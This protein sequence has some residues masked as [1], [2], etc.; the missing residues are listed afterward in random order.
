MS[1]ARSSWGTAPLIKHS[2]KM[3]DGSAGD[4]GLYPLGTGFEGFDWVQLCAES[5][6]RL[7]G[8]RVIVQDTGRRGVEGERVRSRIVGNGS[9]T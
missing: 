3:R 8:S 9:H 4:G 6:S 7:G 1:E 2:N 5:D